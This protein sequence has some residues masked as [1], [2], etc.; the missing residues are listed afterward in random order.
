MPLSTGDLREEIRAVLLPA[1]AADR[2]R[3]RGGTR[4]GVLVPLY[5]DG[6]DLHA[7]F[8]QRREDLRRHAGEISFPGGRK[9]EEDADLSATALREAHEEVGL[10]PTAV[11]LLGAL[12]PTSTIATGYAVYPSVGLI[13]PGQEWTLSAR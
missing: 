2:I 8:T 10:S 11:E 7:V 6:D 9:D 13:E 1:Q 5:V 12:Q 4:A 3:A